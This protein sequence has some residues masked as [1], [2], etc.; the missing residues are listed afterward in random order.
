M[1][2]QDRKLIVSIA[3]LFSMILAKYMFWIYCANESLRL[4]DLGCS[5]VQWLM[6]F[7]LIASLLSM[8]WFGVFKKED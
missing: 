3:M 4:T 5:A 6:T 8:F 7:V 1:N 2:A